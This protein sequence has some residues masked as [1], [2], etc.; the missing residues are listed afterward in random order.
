MNAKEAAEQIAELYC[1]GQD[2][3]SRKP[4]EVYG[5][6]VFDCLYP[7]VERGP[8]VDPPPLADDAT[9]LEHMNRFQRMLGPVK[10]QITQLIVSDSADGVQVLGFD[11]SKLAPPK[12]WIMDPD[13]FRRYPYQSLVKGGST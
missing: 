8:T 2:A 4:R 9:P 7:L 1:S 6:F 10:S 3:L 5:V 13:A 11:A 12:P